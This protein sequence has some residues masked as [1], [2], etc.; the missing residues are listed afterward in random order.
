MSRARSLIVGVVLVA[1]LLG[2]L[3]L[4]RM[5]VRQTG[6]AAES[7]EALEA[8]PELEASDAIHREQRDLLMELLP[9]IT[10]DVGVADLQA[11]LGSVYSGE[12]IDI[13]EAP[14]CVGC[15]VLAWRSFR[16]AFDADGRLSR[17]DLRS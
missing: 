8:L 2:N 15:V 7:L 17:V 13:V 11:Y 10:L 14:Q 6:A 4:A 1:S 12:A 3:A 5:Y 16:F 9:A